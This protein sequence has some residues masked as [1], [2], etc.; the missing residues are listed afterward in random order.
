METLNRV[1]ADCRVLAC[2]ED[3]LAAFAPLA[4]AAGFELIAGPKADVLSR[5]CQAIRKI[6]AIRQCAAD[7]VVRATGDNPF[8]F[9]DAAAA[10]LGEAVTRG[11][12]YAGY[13]ALPYGAGVEIIKAGALFQAEA[14]AAAGGEREHVCPFL[15]NHPERFR[16]HR[17]PAPQAWQGSGIRLTVDTPED[18]T[19]AQRLYDAL[20]SVP[21]ELRGKGETVISVFRKTF[22]SAA[23]G[24]EQ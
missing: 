7:W 9:T 14:E 3:S 18:Y 20:L 13:D 12:D 8:V 5:Y 10:L 6:A 21:P 19:R 15:Y 17:P 24:G 23:E 16:L 2:P 1:P 4:A 22:P 11:A